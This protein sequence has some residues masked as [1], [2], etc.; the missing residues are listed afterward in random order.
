MR[1]PARRSGE[2][3][4]HRRGQPA[5]DLP[6]HRT[7]HGIDRGGHA[8]DI[9]AD[10]RPP[11]RASRRHDRSP[12][13]LDLVRHLDPSARLEHRRVGTAHRRLSNGGWLDPPAR[14]RPAPPRGNPRRAA[15]RPGPGRRRRRRANLARKRAGGGRARPGRMRRRDAGPRR[16]GRSPPGPRRRRRAIAAYRA[17]RRRPGAGLDGAGG[18]PAA[19]RARARHDPRPGRPGRHPV[20]GRL[21]CAGAP[22]RPALLGRARRRAGCG[23]RQELRPA[24]PA[25]AGGPGP[26]GRPA[27]PGRRA[28]AR[29]PVRRARPARARHG[30]AAR[31]AARPGRRGAGRLWLERPL[32]R[33]PRLRQPGA[34]ELRHRRRGHAATGPRPPDAAAGPGAG[35]RH[36]LPAG[37]RRPAWPD[38]TPDHG[39]R[40]HHAHLARPGRHAADGLA[41]RHRRPLAPETPD[42]LADGIEATDWGPARRVRPPGAI[43]G[44]AMRWDRP[45]RDLGSAP[46]AWAA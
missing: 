39:R 37:R 30:P 35:P 34:D 5:I 45:A 33:P 40:Q 4:R 6:R 46:A 15:I 1:R 32:A 19:R 44:A 20:P 22:D 36:R 16:L 7:R 28:G 3:A 24:R 41:R 26:L 10:R 21:R 18:P 11:R 14:Q 31:P 23:A 2:P 43:D 13:R 27:H 9:R 25:H 8:G 12:P 17:G 38:A 42:D 29:L